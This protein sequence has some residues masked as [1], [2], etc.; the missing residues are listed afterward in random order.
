MSADQRFLQ[1]AEPKTPWWKTAYEKTRWESD[2]EQLLTFIH[3]TEIAL[4]LRWQE[5]GD[6]P[7]HKKERLAMEVASE[8]LLAVKIRKLG[9]PD[10]CS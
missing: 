6:D 8:D 4:F 9:W 5:L 1:S 2:K 3:A 10:P 7:S